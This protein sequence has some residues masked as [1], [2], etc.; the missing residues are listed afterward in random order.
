MYRV[1]RLS[2]DR[3]RVKLTDKHREPQT[4]QMAKFPKI[5]PVAGTFTKT[6]SFANFALMATRHKPS[7]RLEAHRHESAFF[8]VVIRGAYY[9]GCL[10]QTTLCRPCSVRYLAAGEAHSNDFGVGTLCL[11]V[12]IRP[13]YV[14]ALEK[15]LCNSTSGEIRHT[16]AQDIGRQLWLD[17]NLRDNLTEFASHSA[18]LDLT[19]LSRSV[20]TGRTVSPQRW[21]EDVREYLDV[22]CTSSLRLT[23]LT[24]A[25]NHHPTHVSREF[26]RCFGKTLV[27]FVRERRIVRAMELL[28]CSELSV[29]DI[30]LKCG[31]FDQ[32][33]FTHVFRRQLQRTP[34]QYRMVDAGRNREWAKE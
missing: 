8:T 16:T 22:Y 7:S 5:A 2:G 11:N 3:L 6:K 32:S 28:R 29:A 12:E 27:Q 23:N 31:F 19:G 25:T 1:L 20:K 4:E 10:G 33:H 14:P 9:E 17:F 15:M 30:S 24:E 18:I 21:L 13:H 34:A 26:R